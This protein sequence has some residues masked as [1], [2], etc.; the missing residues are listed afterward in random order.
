MKKFIFGLMLLVSMLGIV[1]CSMDSS[2]SDGSAPVDETEW[3]LINKTGV[4]LKIAYMSSLGEPAQEETVAANAKYTVKKRDVYTY[5]IDNVT[6]AF[7]YTT[8][9]L[10]QDLKETT[11]KAIGVEALAESFEIPQDNYWL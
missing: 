2:D 7:F 4:T 10:N 11:A 8:S 5:P 3:T 6:C 1:G 9:N